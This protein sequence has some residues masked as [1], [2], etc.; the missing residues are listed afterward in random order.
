MN[1]EK[2][3]AGAQLISQMSD[4]LKNNYNYFDNSFIN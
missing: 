2:V 4:Q 3:Q 1:G